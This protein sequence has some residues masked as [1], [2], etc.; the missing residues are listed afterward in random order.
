MKPVVGY[1]QQCCVCLLNIAVS[2]WVC[3]ASQQHLASCQKEG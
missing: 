2:C 1:I 3:R